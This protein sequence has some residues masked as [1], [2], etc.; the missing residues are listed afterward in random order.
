MP[1]KVQDECFRTIKG[2]RYVNWCDVLGPDTEAEAL[3][4]KKHGFKHRIFRH[5]DGFKRVFVRAV[6]RDAI[7]NSTP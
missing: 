1:V 2:E 7:A 3:K 6:D 5:P 4:I